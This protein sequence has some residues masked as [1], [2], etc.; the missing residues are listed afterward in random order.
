MRCLWHAVLLLAGCSGGPEVAPGGIV[1][2]NP[3]IDAILAQVAPADIAAVSSW[4]HD[5]E[6]ASAPLGWARAHPALGVTAEEIIA[7]KPRLLLTGNLASSGT[8]AALAKAGVPMRTFGVPATVADS[9][10]DC[11]LKTVTIKS[12][13]ISETQWNN[14]ED[15]DIDSTIHIAV[16]H[17]G[18][19]ESW[20]LYT[21]SGFAEAVSELLGTDVSYTEQGMQDD[22]YASMEL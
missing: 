6:S 8:N 11:T 16:V 15:C 1:S 12:I 21:D 4:S 2:N 17:T 22:G 14:D 18:K 5:P 20:R 7:A 3:C 9:I 19:D 13:H 10:W